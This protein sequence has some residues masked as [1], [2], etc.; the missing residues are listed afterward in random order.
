MRDRIDLVGGRRILD[1]FESLIAVD[2]GALGGRNILT[3]F[4]RLFVDLAHHHVVVDH[5][6]IGVFQTL[7]EAEPA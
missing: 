4:E 2:D 6:V 5:V 3:Q 7:H 1:Q